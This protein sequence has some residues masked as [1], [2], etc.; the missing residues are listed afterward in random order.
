MLV[1]F[2]LN[3]NY[4]CRHLYILDNI[5]ELYH[6]ITL[7]IVFRLI[8]SCIFSLQSQFMK[9]ALGAMHD[10]QAAIRTDPSYSLAYFNAANIYFKNRQF[11]QVCMIILLF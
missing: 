11:R 3:I 1:K 2:T 10:F 5:F 4:V 7:H 8:Y 6:L 9:D